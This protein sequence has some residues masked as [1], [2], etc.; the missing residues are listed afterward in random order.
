MPS[1]LY[2]D[3]R[4]AGL[5]LRWGNGFMSPGGAEEL[6]ALLAGADLTGLTGLD[7]GCGVGGYTELLVTRHGARHV[8]GV[9]IDEAL[10]ERARHRVDDRVSGSRLSF[11]AIPPG[12]L[13]FDDAHFDFVLCKEVLVRISEKRPILSE[14]YRVLRP[15]GLLFLSD[16]HCPE[17]PMTSDMGRWV[18]EE[19]YA[20]ASLGE[21]AAAVNAVG[22]QAVEASDRNDWFRSFAEAECRQLEIG[23]AVCHELSER[24]LRSLRR[25][26]R[27]RSLLASQG[28]LRPGHIRARKPG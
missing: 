17:G 11:T 13:P 4:L 16:W 21:I 18:A 15:G 14:L 25:A 24:K 9:D 6:E 19:G 8:V 7:F 10:I 5:E 27:V 3:E 12:P 22:F 1:L 28:Q 20:V 2:D 26:A 23:E